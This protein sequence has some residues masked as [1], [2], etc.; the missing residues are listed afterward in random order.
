MEIREQGLTSPL[1]TLKSVSGSG[2][3]RKSGV[4]A[5]PIPNAEPRAENQK[6]ELRKAQEAE[7]KGKSEARAGRDFVKKQGKRPGNL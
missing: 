2:V 1:Q 7:S 5:G 3:Q 6:S 4:W